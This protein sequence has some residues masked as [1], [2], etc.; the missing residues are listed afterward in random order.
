MCDWVTDRTPPTTWAFAA[1][2]NTR[3]SPMAQAQRLFDSM[4]HSSGERRGVSPPVRC[5]N[6]R[7]NAAPLAFC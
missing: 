4:M 3:D 5:P 6:R 2:A 7:A 1:H